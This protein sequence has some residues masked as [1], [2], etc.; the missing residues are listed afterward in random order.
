[1]T[2]EPRPDGGSTVRWRSTYV[3]AGPV[4]AVILRAA[5][6]D[7]CRRLARPAAA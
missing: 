7:A 1:M 3:H 6:R 5:V 2:V 4:T